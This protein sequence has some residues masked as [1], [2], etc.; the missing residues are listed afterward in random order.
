MKFVTNKKKCRPSAIA[1]LLLI[2][3]IFQPLI[4]YG[5]SKA[6][7]PVGKTIG[8]TASLDGICVVNTAEFKSK[9]GNMCCPSK[10]AG[11]L[12]GDKIIGINE[13]E[14]ESAKDLEN[15]LNNANSNEMTIKIMRN[16]NE[17]DLKVYAEKSA[18]SDSYKLGLWI[19]DSCS[20]IG[21]LTYYDPETRNFGALGHGICDTD[22]N[23]IL[24]TS[25][26]LLNAEITSVKRG[27]K[28]SPGELIGVFSEKDDELGSITSNSSCGI[29]GKLKVSP[30][31]KSKMQTAEYNE[32]YEGSATILSNIEKNTI[33]EYSAEIIKINKDIES[34]K[35]FVIKITDKRLLEKTGGIVR[36]MSG[37][38]II[39]N[40]KLVG[41]VTHVFVNDPTRGYGIFIE[42]MLAETEKIK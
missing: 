37:S 23:L 1:L 25:G 29:N 14:I 8:I 19:K 18:Q 42:N 11:I 2:L 28:G 21:T 33:E 15:I 9:D 7:I 36:G 24:I 16:G 30:D 40:G 31:N 26:K 10:D 6:L 13:N 3:F 35:S 34:E 41:A 5:E 17:K 22:N 38:P 39:Q 27:E 32:I 12:P 20:G 4:S